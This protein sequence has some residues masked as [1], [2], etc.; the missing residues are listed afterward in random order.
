M[1]FHY[2]SL[3][4]REEENYY[5][6]SLS[7]SYS[8][9]YSYGSNS[10]NKAHE[11]AERS[12]TSI[13]SSVAEIIAEN[14][15]TGSTDVETVTVDSNNLESISSLDTSIISPEQS[16]VGEK[17]TMPSIATINVDDNEVENVLATPTTGEKDTTDATNAES[18][19]ADGTES[20]SSLAKTM[21]GL[22]VGFTVVAAFL[23]F[24][25]RFHQFDV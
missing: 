17:N 7:Y 6:H 23:M 24:S 21:I 15:S 12:I 18:V 13:P 4:H 10:N 14:E 25:K 11:T 2:F 1:L 5:T 3:I 8:Y 9:S 19:I 20:I 22:G 16:S